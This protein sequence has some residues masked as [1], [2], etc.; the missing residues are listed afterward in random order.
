MKLSTFNTYLNLSERSGVIYNSFTD[1]AVFVSN[2]VLNQI[3]NGN[4]QNLDEFIINTAFVDKQCNEFEQ[5][6]KNILS[7][8]NNTDSYHLI[9]NPTLECI[10]SCWYCYEQHTKGRIN[11]DIFERIK[12]FITFLSE[13]YPQLTISFFGGEPM[14]CYKSSLMPIV[15]FAHHT[16]HSKGKR[17]QFNMTTNGY[18]F[19]KERISEMITW[20]FTGAQITLDGEEKQHNSVRFLGNGQPSYNRIVKNIQLLT[21]A[22]CHITLRLNCTHK[23]INNLSKISQSFTELSETAKQHLRIDCHIVW[24]EQNKDELQGKMHQLVSSFNNH[25]LLATKMDF[26]GF[27]YADKRSGCVINYNGDVYKCTAIDFKNVKRDGFLSKNGE[28]LWENN[29]LENRMNSKFK[30]KLC[31][32]CRIWPLCHGG[33]TSKSLESNENYCLYP[34]DS[35]KDQM[36]I[37]RL[38]YIITNKHYE[39]K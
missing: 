24:Q 14:M 2:D 16:F 4:I 17:F 20:G 9:I 11:N 31:H 37:N 30:N 25:N 33:C 21:N 23:N 15:K 1:K 27:C 3:R 29:S 13:R 10:F 6:S 39:N 32:N 35:Q 7:I 36:V 18:L 5:Y 19:T 8:E 28:I 38:E 22:G 34:T 12:L 26:R